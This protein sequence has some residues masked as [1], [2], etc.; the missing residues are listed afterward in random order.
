MVNLS[1]RSVIKASGVLGV[2]ATAGALPRW[3]PT[4]FADPAVESRAV[5]TAG[6]TLEA[7]GVPKA[8]GPQRYRRIVAGP[9]WP[10]VV[11]TEL[12]P[13]KPGRD[14]RRVGVASIVQT[15]D[16]HIVDAES[17]VRAEFI[18][19]DN[20]SAFR[21]HEKMTTHGAITLVQ[22][23]NSLPGGP[24]SGRAFDC[25]VSTGDNT[26]NHEFAEL[27]WMLTLLSGGTLRP[28]TG[29]PNRYEGV[30]VW[31]SALYWQAESP[32]ADIY[33]RRGF[34]Q[35]PGLLASTITPITSP[36]LKMRWYS[37]FGNHDDSV[38]GTAPSGIGFIDEF[39]VGGTK[40]D[41]PSGQAQIDR[42][43][44][45]FRTDPAAVP[46]LFGELM[47]KG[48]VRAV[49]PDARRRPFTTR[50]YMAEH[51][52]PR[53]TG[54]GP[55]GHGFASDAP[56][57]GIT[58][59]S[60]PIAPGVV[61]I[62]M[63]TTN[64]AGFVDG[65]IGDVQ[66]RWI[67]RLLTRGSRTYYDATGRKVTHAADDTLFVMFSHHTSTTMELPIPDPEHPLEARFTGKYLVEFFKRFP[68]V[69][70]WVNG[71]THQN[72]ITPHRGRTAAQS[73]WEINTASHIDFPQNA[74][75]VEVC[76]NKDGTL[77]LFA[78][79]IESAA[80]YS[81]DYSDHSVTGLASMYREFSYNDIG[82]E[83]SRLGGPLD[84]NVELLLTS[85]R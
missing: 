36:G 67:E 42:I 32:M 83:P 23:I 9:A 40:I 27:D 70:A 29:D 46:R 51:L 18:H 17:P 39:Y 44:A 58:Y 41:V 53:Y 49:T 22:R 72:K 34:P 2:A 38:Q 5:S 20:G 82:R 13:A 24:F 31:G 45:A 37:V 84:H 16:I 3:S 75:I 11:R 81:V 57:S 64:H 69:V 28:S 12:A 47:T 56:T 10:L 68:N 71:H 80:P 74:R 50:Q 21:P 52:K 59:Y 30:Q 76:D 65:S 6:T 25:L 8:T 79:L 54:P 78:T 19:L 33:K 73:F 15:T 14:D 26:D 43:S 66:L 61:G 48:P 77:S 7:V 60:F 55:V 1:R 35:I 62:S 85:P 63:D 4:A